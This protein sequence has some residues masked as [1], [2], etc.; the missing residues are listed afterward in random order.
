[1]I[2]S[3]GV[4]AIAAA[5]GW[6]LA[7]RRAP[8]PVLPLRLFTSRVF[9]VASAV[10][11]I[12]GFALFGALTFIPLFLQ[13]VHGVSPTL[14]GV[15]LLPMVLGLLL[16]SVASGQL[17]SRFGRYKVYPI[18]GTAVMALGLYLLSRMNE[19]TPTLTMSLN[20]LVLGLGLG[21][22]L[23]VLVIAVQNSVGYSDLGVATSGATFF[24]SI[25]GSFGVAIFGAIFSNRL[26]SELKAALAKL[27]LPPGFDVAKLHASPVGGT[28]SQQL[29]PAL[30][31]LVIHAY[32]LSIHAVFLSAV[33]VAL[34]AFV[35]TWFLPEVPLRATSE[36]NDYGEG[37]GG[38]PTQR[39]SAGELERALSKLADADL[40]RRGYE[41]L[42][43][44]ASLDL[45]AGSCWVL[46]RLARLGS[47]SGE[48]LAR[49]ARVPMEQGRPYV[50]KLV[51]AEL[52][53][54]RDGLIELTD[55]GRGAADRLT[56][57]R[58]D[59]LAQLCAG[60]SPD[61]HAD[62]AEMLNRL[63]SAILGDDADRRLLSK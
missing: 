28:A 14:S 59:G 50:D 47:L 27:T 40:R 25:G 13:V 46:A 57:A 19:H 20:F 9:C 8:E 1:V 60:W 30:R 53:A 18:V 31:V 39:S 48:E 51:E 26:A 22:V 6:A 29:P 12:A 52:V 33:P 63:A 62:L 45:P 54:R 24:R 5:V 43:Q 35:L 56:A 4:A 11:F 21:L 44:M 15:H 36:A 49:Q 10:G 42:A 17:I 23:Q 38:T 41:R 2:I 7:E 16:T 58:R 55:L 61:Q 3:L 34:A 32:A 37:L